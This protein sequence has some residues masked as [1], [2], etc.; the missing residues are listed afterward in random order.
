M[1]QEPILLPKPRRL[2]CL[3]GMHT[4]R[5]DRLIWL[6]GEHASSLLRTGLA[7]QKALEHVGPKWELTARGTDSRRV[8][9]AVH[10]DPSLVPQP[11]GYRL[12]ISPDEVRIVAHDP[13]GAF[14]AAMTLRQI[15]RQ[16]PK[17]SLPCLRIDDWPDFLSRGVTL[18]IS[19]DKVPT[20]NTLYSLV[21]LLVEWK[22]NQFQLYTE[23]AFA[24]RNH[25]D[26]WEKASPMT[27]E[28]IL[29][30]DEHCRSR[31]VELVPNQNSFGHM[32]RW[33]MHDRYK[34]LAEH[35]ERLFSLCPLDPGSIQLI[36]ELMDE[37]LPHFTSRLVNVGC[38]ETFDLGQGRSKEACEK[39]GVGRVY[40]DF[41]LKI[42]EIVQKKGRTMQFWGD[43]IM[44]HPELIPELP[45][46]I[47][48]LEWGYEANHPF[49]KDGEKFAE[50]GVPF[51][52]CPGTSSW[53]SIAGRTD[54]AVANLW[55]A[56]ENGLAHGAVGYL[57]TDWG[58]NG[59]WQPLPVSYLGYAYGAAVSWAAQPN[60]D[61]DLPRVLDLHAFHDR[62]GV[63]GRLVYDLGNA[64]KVPGVLLG[65]CSVLS[66]ILYRPEHPLTEGWMAEL[67]VESLERTE[68]YIDQTISRISGASLDRPDSR[69]I[70]DEYRNAAAMLRHA[71]RL[72]I[73]RMLEDGSGIA[74]LPSKT[75]KVLADELA[76]IVSEHRRLWLARNRPGGLDDSTGRLERLL[77]LYRSQ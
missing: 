65:N 36:G 8:G 57:N 42:H 6:G 74:N 11:Q 43:I 50:A 23:H 2:V 1:T 64:Y 51:Y 59:H 38:D 68:E 47:I 71:C 3:E 22:I 76:G 41:L 40:L 18:D 56:A 7:I 37:L 75:R 46:D 9:A 72:A 33:L 54:N 21:D 39:H 45:A 19:R 26:V 61:I 28:Q 60:R 52:V 73:V 29:E 44:H 53:N 69:L 24:Y 4:L 17:G 35:P 66:L 27:G 55:N 67:T 77:E 5:P 15:T 58:D 14:Y 10:V 12:T 63:M 30:L 48:A 49:A 62:A 31:F 16:S 32:H 70:V 34:P 13:A 25:R 20:M